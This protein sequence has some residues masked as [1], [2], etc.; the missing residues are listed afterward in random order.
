MC[1]YY[2]VFEIPNPGIGDVPISGCWDYK[3]WL[4]LYFCVLNKR[5]TN[6]IFVMNKN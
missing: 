3:N 1:C 6:F 2:T 4:K 5:N